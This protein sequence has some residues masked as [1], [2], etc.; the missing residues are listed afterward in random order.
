MEFS[1]RSLRTQSHRV[2]PSGKMYGIDLSADMLENCKRRAASFGIT[3]ENN[4]MELVK[5]DATILPFPDET[6]DFVVSTQ[7]LEYVPDI[8]KALREIHRVLKRGTGR[9]VILDTDFDALIIHTD[10]VDL[11]KRMLAGYAPHVAHNHLPRHLAHLLSKCGFYVANLENVAIL[12]LEYTPERFGY[13]LCDFIANYVRQQAAAAA[14]GDEE[15][16]KQA[17]DDVNAW[18]ADLQRQAD[19]GSFFFSMNRYQFTA[20]KKNLM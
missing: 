14:A 13:H 17:E 1:L 4:R 5:G 2:G 12:N 3:A 8:E 20:L 19:R 15:M 6:F 16:K 10:D 18:L 11:N 7:V 9:A